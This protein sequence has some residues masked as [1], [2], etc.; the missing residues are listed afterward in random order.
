M[1]WPRD[2]A[3]W[4]AAFAGFLLGSGFGRAN[5]PPIIA[6]VRSTASAG[7]RARRR[8][9]LT[10]GGLLLA[11]GCGG[12]VGWQVSES[13]QNEAIAR[14]LTGGDPA[15]GPVLMTRYGCGGCHTIPGVPGAD[16]QVGPTLAG[17]RARVFVGGVA[18]NTAS[19]LIDWIVNPRALSPLTAMPVT[20]ISASE[21]RDVA[22]FLY[23]RG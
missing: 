1:R 14:A 10:S 13:R 16:G 12:V 4:L 17:L 5:D 7:G 15:R 18:R 3:I 8:W 20:G 19:N 22:A 21:A 2:G 6:S 11:L 23:S 9:L